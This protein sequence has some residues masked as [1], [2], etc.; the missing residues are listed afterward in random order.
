MVTQSPLQKP[1]A[2]IEKRKKEVPGHADVVGWYADGDD[3][4]SVSIIVCGGGGGDADIGG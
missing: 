3:G 4:F 1:E 2:A